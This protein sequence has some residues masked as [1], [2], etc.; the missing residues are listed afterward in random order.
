MGA[1][2]E[3][4][5]VKRYAGTVKIL[6]SVLALTL[7]GLMV[8]LASAWDDTGHMVIA[9]I[10]YNHMTPTAR[11]E[12]DRLL[13]VGATSKASDFL[14]SACWADDIRRERRETGPWHYIDLYF[15]SDAKPA[16]HKP[17]AENA[18]WA[19]SKFKAILKDK[20]QPE[21]DRAEALRFLIHFVGDLH[22]PLHT[23]SRETDVLP[24]GDAGGNKF[25]IQAPASFV[26]DYPPRNLHALWDEGCGLFP[27]FGR[28]F[29]PLDGEGREKIET[30][31]HKIERDEPKARKAASNTDPM[32]WAKE[33]EGLSK[34]FVY[35]LQEGGTPSDEYLKKGEAISEMRAAQ[36]GYRLAALL[37]DTLR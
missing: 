36:A 1:C 31:A 21:A 28:N 33:G 35:N 12:A 22:Q 30:I 29:R 23:V 11:A 2:Q 25:P 20:S 19:I 18:V 16:T 27:S 24:A 15:R 10:A 37:N 7:S 4:G 8:C 26:G 5:K 32:D 9:E 13:K 3:Y 17:D 6:R 34:R 14:T